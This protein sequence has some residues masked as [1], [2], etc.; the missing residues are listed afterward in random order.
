M[1]KV[2]SKEAIRFFLKG[3]NVDPVEAMDSITDSIIEDMKGEKIDH[4]DGDKVIELL[5]LS[6]NF[7]CRTYL[8]LCD[9]EAESKFF[10]DNFYKKVDEIAMA[11]DVETLDAYYN[12][13]M[14]REILVKRAEIINKR[15]EE[16]EMS[17]S[18][19]I[20]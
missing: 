7:R 17:A 3:I 18:K 12:M 1:D 8:E 9:D 15:K 5:M 20:I 6:L 14:D 11:R 13:L 10:D 4:D 16:E 19:W 2:S